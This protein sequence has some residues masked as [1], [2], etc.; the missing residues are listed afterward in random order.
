MQKYIQPINIA[1]NVDF[2]PLMTI[3]NFLPE[4]ESFLRCVYIPL[5]NDQTALEPDEEFRVSVGLMDNRPGLVV[6]ATSSAVVTII[7]DDGKINLQ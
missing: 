7:D 2:I 3:V 4:E 6:G 5:I 1:G